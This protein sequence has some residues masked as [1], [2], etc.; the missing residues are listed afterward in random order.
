MLVKVGL[1][2]LFSFVGVHEKLLSGLEDQP[3]EIAIC[4]ARGAPDESCYL[5]IPVWHCN[6]IAGQ[7]C[8]VKCRDENGLEPWACGDCDCTAR[9]EEKL[10]KTGESFL[11][12]LCSSE[13]S[14]RYKN[15]DG[16]REPAVSV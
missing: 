14:R 11:K 9:L 1:E 12:L 13:Q 15:N 7:D 3:T 16:G 4:D 5:E 8:G 6:I 2:L 10:K